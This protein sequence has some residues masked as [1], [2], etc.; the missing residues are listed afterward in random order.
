[1]SDF[2][3]AYRET[4]K[5]ERGY[6]NDPRDRGGETWRGIARN[7]WPNWEGW[8]LID[9]IKTN[10]GTSLNLLRKA[11]EM[12]DELEVKVRWFYKE[13]FWDKLHIDSLDIR[14]SLEVYDTAVNQGRCIAVQYLQQALNM[15]ND[16][17]RHYG[18]I[19]TDG[20]IG[21]GTL[22]AYRAYMDT[23]ARIQ[24]RSSELN[25]KVL[26]KA[27]NGMQFERYKTIVADTPTQERFF[28]GWI[29]RT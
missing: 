8:M 10:C 27:L 28:Y 16:N 22:K 9:E 2:E 18:D 25:I 20:I 17:Q 21:P 14:I 3:S 11:L 5:I 19:E 29:Q 7:R 15:L 26:L 12:D 6:S 23:A 1:M 24:G 13:N 4:I